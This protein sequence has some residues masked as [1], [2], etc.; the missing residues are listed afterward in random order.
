MLKEM[1]NC[2]MS[3]KTNFIKT[4]N[5]KYEVVRICHLYVHIGKDGYNRKQIYK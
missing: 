1:F 3:F 2:Q 4:H 5:T